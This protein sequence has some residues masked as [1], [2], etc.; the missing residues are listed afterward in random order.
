MGGM[1]TPREGVVYH[2]RDLDEVVGAVGS[3]LCPYSVR[4]RP[5]RYQASMRFDRLGG[6]AFVTGVYGP[7]L[8]LRAESLAD[9]YVI[10]QS[11]R[12]AFRA[13][14]GGAELSFRPGDMHVIY[15]GSPVAME[16]SAGCRMAVLRVDRRMIEQHA[17]ALVDGDTPAVPEAPR[18]DGLRRYFELLYRESQRPGSRLREGAGARYAEQMLV[19]LLLGACG[20]ERAGERG[21]APYYVRRAEEFIDAHLTSDIGVVDIVRAAG[22]SARALQYGFR[23]W[24]GMGPAAWL[25][26]RRLERARDELAAAEP[27]QTTVT[28]VALGLG[29][30]HLGKFSAAYR[31]RFGEP[32]ARTLRRR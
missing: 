11:Q 3:I 30:L 29:F 16:W 13:R 15:P 5:E 12:G 20:D 1:G 26:Q 17:S 22:V 31:A 27:G 24:R 18:H 23:R 8:E 25:R 2:T 7:D 21:V 19:A 10:E 9:F 28:T 6:L 14:G 4:G 32:P